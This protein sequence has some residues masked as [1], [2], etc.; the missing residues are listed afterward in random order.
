METMKTTNKRV[1]VL[2]SI[3]LIISPVL[4]CMA[5]KK[6]IAH[7]ENSKKGENQQVQT[8]PQKNEKVTWTKERWMEEY[9]YDQG[10]TYRSSGG[11][12]GFILGAVV[13]ML[14]GKGF[15]GKKVTRTE[16]YNGWF[17]SST[18]KHYSYENK[19]T[20]H[21]GAIIGCI[22]G[23]VAG[24]YLGKKADKQYYIDVPK[25]IR[26]QK[27]TSSVSANSLT[28]FLLFGPL[29]AIL[30]TWAF[31]TR[32]SVTTGGLL[33]LPDLGDFNTGLVA[34]IVSSIT[35]IIIAAGSNNRETHIKMW[36]ESSQEKKLESTLDIRFMSSEPSVFTIIP[37]KLPGGETYHEYKLDIDRA[38]F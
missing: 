6:L 11:A 3:A 28:G 10:A 37:K 17:K 15:Q 25:Y 21:L 9:R 34:Y 38:H 23:G 12:L 35:R 33:N 29:L 22:A 1:A 26:I 32:S 7:Q 5:Q 19:N 18:T 13:G 2:L 16:K 27:T 20:P 30:T 14:I 36:E 8:Q 4:E 24:Y 31:D